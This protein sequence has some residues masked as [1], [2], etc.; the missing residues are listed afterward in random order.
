VATDLMWRTL[1]LKY[2]LQ[3]QREV[4]RHILLYVDPVSVEI[5]R[6]RRLRRRTY[7]S[8]G[9]NYTWHIDGYDKL[10]PYGFHIS[11]C[12]DGYSRRI[13]W[14]NCAFTNHDS[15]V[16]CGYYLSCLEKINGLPFRTRTDC[17]TENVLVAAC[18]CFLTGN[19]NGHIYGT[20]PGN[21]RIESWWSFYRRNR[22]QWFIEL[23]EDLIAMDAFH[24]GNVNEKEC[25]RY[26]FM[27]VIN[28][29]LAEVRCA[30]N[31][32][33]I[34]SSVGSRCPA[35]VP[36]EL[37]YLPEHPYVNCKSPVPNI[38]Q[39]I[40]DAALTITT[41]CENSEYQEYLEYLCFIHGWVK[42]QTAFESVELYLKLITLI[43]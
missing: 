31:T 42:P 25:L 37:F 30:W 10:C 21:Q 16:I 4:V 24:T 11:G 35:G 28:A 12:I 38:P 43:C 26:C 19:R 34:R 36:D 14:L 9:P 29:D 23:F 40:T 7:V 41:A 39:F 2:R 18:Q 13:L 33:R 8:L 20:S 3:V 22:S 32:H 17:G 5:R 1:R 27:D 6:R 15:K